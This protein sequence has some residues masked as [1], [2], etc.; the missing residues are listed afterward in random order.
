M[1]MTKAL[2]PSSNPLI[3][4]CDIQH[5]ACS[6]VPWFHESCFSFD[7]VYLFY[8]SLFIILS[9][10]ANVISILD[11][12]ATSSLKLLQ[13]IVLLYKS[14]IVHSSGRSPF[15]F[16]MEH[17][18]GIR[19]YLMK[20][21][22]HIILN[23]MVYC[24]LPGKH[25]LVFVDVGLQVIEIFPALQFQTHVFARCECLTFN[26]PFLRRNPVLGYI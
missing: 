17:K 10:F 20:N 24:Y 12:T 15:S 5:H 8:H 11:Q 6:C 14:Y 1:R 4:W 7:A 25:F 22:P 19:I 26:F 21:L 16:S 9:W 13:Y 3:L 2:S 18:R 23:W